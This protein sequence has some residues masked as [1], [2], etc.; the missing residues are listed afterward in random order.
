MKKLILLSVFTISAIALTAVV[1]SKVW[2][3]ASTAQ[4]LL[5]EDNIEVL[6]SGEIRGMYVVSSGVCPSPCGY[7]KWVS[8]RMGGKEECHPSD[9]C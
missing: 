1:K 6:T 5:L 2:L 3:P 9:C 7:K 4:E 8:C